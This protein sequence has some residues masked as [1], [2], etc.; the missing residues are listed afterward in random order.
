MR[1][2]CDFVLVSS[3]LSTTVARWTSATTAER[4][5]KKI[6]SIKFWSRLLLWLHASSQRPNDSTNLCWWP[7]TNVN[8]ERMMWKRWYDDG[9]ATMK[10]AASRSEFR[11]TTLSPSPAWLASFLKKL[12]M[13]S[14]SSLQ[15]IECCSRAMTKSEKKN[16]VPL[17]HSAIY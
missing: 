1:L 12:E 7:T 9:N 13:V 5:E 4:R 2:R 14:F 17:H 11:W 15:S 10:A 6:I 8:G 3:Q 16:Y